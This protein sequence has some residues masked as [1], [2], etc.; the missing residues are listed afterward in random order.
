MDTTQTL[1]QTTAIVAAD[2][3]AK[4]FRMGIADMRAAIESKE[5]TDADA[6]REL[7]RR[8]VKAETASSWISSHVVTFRN[9]VASRL[10]VKARAIPAPQPRKGS[11]PRSVSGP[12]P[13]DINGLVEHIATSGIDIPTLMG[14]LATRMNVTA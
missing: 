13:T 1:E 12:L 3:D 11:I 4:L 5:I 9:V 7:E 10:G 8:I 14:A 2:L 6:L